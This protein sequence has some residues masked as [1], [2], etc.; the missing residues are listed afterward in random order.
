M[1]WMGFGQ[2]PGA[3]MSIDHLTASNADYAASG[4]AAVERTTLVLLGPH[5]AHV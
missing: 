3:K 1:D 2:Q 4:D 5:F